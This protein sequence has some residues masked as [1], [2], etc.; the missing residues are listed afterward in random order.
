[1]NY[2][3]KIIGFITEKYRKNKKLALLAIAILALGLLALTRSCNV[4]E[5][6]ASATVESTNETITETITETTETQTVEVNVNEPLTEENIAEVPATV[7]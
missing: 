1:M 6:T 2:L 5:E 7:K 4:A 3:N